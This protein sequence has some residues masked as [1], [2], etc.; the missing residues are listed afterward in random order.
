MRNSSVHLVLLIC[1]ASTTGLG[2]QVDKARAALD[3][4]LANPKADSESRY[5]LLCEAYRLAEAAEGSSRERRALIDEIRVH[6]HAL[7]PHALAR[8]KAQSKTAKALLDSAVSYQQAGWN[9]TAQRVLELALKLDP[10]AE[11]DLVARLR[12]GLPSANRTLFETF[13][14]A[15]YPYGGAPWEINDRWIASPAVDPDADPQSHLMQAGPVLSGNYGFSLEV[16]MGDQPGTLGIAV[17]V[18]GRGMEYHMVQL[19]FSDT[20]STLSLHSYKDSQF[21]ELTSAKVEL[22]PKQRETWIPVQIKADHGVLSARIA[23]LEPITWQAEW[24]LDGSIGLFITGYTRNP[25]PVR[26]R[27]LQIDGGR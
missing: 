26:F 17:G 21:F 14:G 12:A 10:Y 6:L 4:V 25:N 16:S 18:T 20:L 2:A 23:G 15:I 24:V 7:D 1:M 22:S 11:P 19:K 8:L 9:R 3:R 27:H 5:V 13:E